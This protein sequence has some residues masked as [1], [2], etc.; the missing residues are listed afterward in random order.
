MKPDGHRRRPTQKAKQQNQ[1]RTLE[2]S[3]KKNDRPPC[4]LNLL[5]LE[6][7]RLRSC[8]VKA[9]SHLPIASLRLPGCPVDTCTS[10]CMPH[11]L[12]HSPPATTHHPSPPASCNGWGWEQLLRTQRNL[13]HRQRLNNSFSSAFYFLC[14]LCRLCLKS[15]EAPLSANSR[16]SYLFIY[17]FAVHTHDFHSMALPSVHPSTP[18]PPPPPPVF[19]PYT[20][21]LFL[22]LV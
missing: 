17:L 22:T 16:F 11:S 3:L 20:Q 1:N 13:C 9:F 19:S 7:C 8:L 15:K 12:T 5:R 10:C 6:A 4:G 18:P 21:S 2:G 14:V